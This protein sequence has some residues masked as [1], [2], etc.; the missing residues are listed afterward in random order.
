MIPPFSGCQTTQCCGHGD[1]GIVLRSSITYIH[2]TVFSTYHKSL[3]RAILRV[4]FWKK[5]YILQFSHDH[6]FQI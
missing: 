5:K 2:G 1:N 4:P 3:F 6:K